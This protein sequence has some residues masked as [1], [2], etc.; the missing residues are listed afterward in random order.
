MSRIPECKFCYKCVLD[1]EK[2][3]YLC[4]KDKKNPKKINGYQSNKL[5]FQIELVF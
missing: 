2:Q 4:F 3:I 5:C 1:K